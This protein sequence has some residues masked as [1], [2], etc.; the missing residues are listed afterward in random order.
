MYVNEG[1]T[2]WSRLIKETNPQG[3]RGFA[4]GIFGGTALTTSSTLTNTIFASGTIVA[5]NGFTF[6]DTGSGDYYDDIVWQGGRTATFSLSLK[7]TARSAAAA[8]FEMRV[9]P[10]SYDGATETAITSTICYASTPPRNSAKNSASV[11]GSVTLAHGDS[12]RFKH[13]N[14]NSSS[15]KIDSYG[16]AVVLS[17]VF[18]DDD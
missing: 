11:A 13:S 17:E 16:I 7:C 5:E 1:T 14:I 2:T 4:A 8:S 15:G 18:S 6:S 9:I 12:L 3:G 10:Y